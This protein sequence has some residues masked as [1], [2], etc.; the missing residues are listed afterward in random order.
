MTAQHLAALTLEVW[1]ASGARTEQRR[2]LLLM[3]YAE[4]YYGA[5]LRWSEDIRALVDAARLIT[6][7]RT[8]IDELQYA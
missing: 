3:A 5:P 4:T 6:R 1:R 8:R 7:Q 2:D